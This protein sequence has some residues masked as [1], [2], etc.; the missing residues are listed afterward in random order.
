MEIEKIIIWI[1][2]FIWW[3]ISKIIYDIYEI[4]KKWL[5]DE[6]E[7]DKKIYLKIKDELLPLDWW[8]WF[9]K[10]F[11]F[12]WFTFKLDKVN[13]LFSISDAQIN[14]PSLKFLDKKL[15]KLK[16]D[17]FLEIKNI[18]YEI[19]INTFPKWL[20][21]QTVPPEWEIENPKM[22]EKVVNNLHTY[23]SNIWSKYNIFIDYWRKKFKI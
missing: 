5:V 22:F 2:W 11:N 6:K 19:S 21:M 9:I 20:W 14:N 1:L 16:N 18:V 23:S 8:L 3:L 13:D 15:E 17:L 12:A 10:D 7:F 4:H